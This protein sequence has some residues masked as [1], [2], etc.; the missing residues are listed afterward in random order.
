MTPGE[1]SPRLRRAVSSRLSLMVF[2]LLLL[3]TQCSPMLT[4]PPNVF[5]SQSTPGRPRPPSTTR[6]SWRQRLLPPRVEW[7]STLPHQRVWGATTP[8]GCDESSI[9]IIDVST[10]LSA[11]YFRQRINVWVHM[12]LSAR[13]AFSIKFTQHV[14]V[15][16]LYSRY[17][18]NRWWLSRNRLTATLL[19]YEVNIVAGGEKRTA[20][21][22]M[23]ANLLQ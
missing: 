10:S 4:P 20:L 16:F 2:L 15:L 18:Q 13:Y 8:S 22:T 21:L 14:H 12:M 23:K 5:S 6:T 7:V 1:T 19:M 3:E 11:F 9:I 17:A